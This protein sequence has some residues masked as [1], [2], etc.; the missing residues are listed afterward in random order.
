MAVGLFA[1]Y[2]HDWRWRI[3]RRLEDGLGRQG[4]V[5]VVAYYEDAI[6]K[7]QEH[8]YELYVIG[9]TKSQAQP[10]NSS[11]DV[12]LT[13]HLLDEIIIKRKISHDRIYVISD[14]PLVK[15]EAQKRKIT[16]IYTKGISGGKDLTH[17]VWDIGRFAR[18]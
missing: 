3:H 7:T 18:R 12:V 1:E 16:Q 8:S 14:N 15:S 9:D 11:T 10:I 4:S 2:D 13:M 6:S 5:D 17:L